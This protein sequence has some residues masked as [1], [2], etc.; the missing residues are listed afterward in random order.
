[1]VS[2]KGESEGSNPSSHYESSSSG[3][4]NG[5]GTLASL[6][7]KREKG[8]R[9]KELSICS[10]QARYQK[11]VDC[12]VALGHKAITQENVQGKFR[13]ALLVNSSKGIPDQKEKSGRKKKN[14]HRE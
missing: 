14:Q 13:E 6:S 7:V 8:E 4:S 3:R 11:I 9:G 1:L 10:Q 12:H 5:L 2:Q